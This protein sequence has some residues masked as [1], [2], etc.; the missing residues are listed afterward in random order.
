MLNEYFVNKPMV[1]TKR[2]IILLNTSICWVHGIVQPKIFT[3]FLKSN[4]LGFEA[5]SRVHVYRIE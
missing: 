3:L 1:Q 2:V 5:L 4:I